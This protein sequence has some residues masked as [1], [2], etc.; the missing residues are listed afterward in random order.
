MGYIS[1]YFGVHV[2]LTDLAVR[3]AKPRE[4]PYK[5]FDGNGLYLHVVPSGARR[6]RFKYKFLGTEKLMGLGVYPEISLKE[7]RELHAEAR[8]LVRAN[9][10]P[11]TSRRDERRHAIQKI[12]ST[13][14]AVAKEWHDQQ[15]GRWTADHADRVWVSLKNN[16]FPE[17]G[18]KPVAEIRAQDVIRILRHI[19]QRDALDV[20]SRALQRTA[21]VLRYAV[22]TGRI[23]HNP[24]GDLR[25]VLKT[26]KVQHR[27]AM[28]AE[29]LPEFLR[30]LDDYTGEPITAIAL[31]LLLL[32]FVRPG[33]LR[34]A[35]WSEFDLE[36]SEWRIP[37]ERMKMRE[38]HLVPL[39]HQAMKLLGSLVPIS[40]GREL[41]FPSRNGQGKPMS[42]NT[43][44]FALY[45]MGY[46]KR[47]T[48]HGFRATASTI[49]N[50]HGFRPDVIER[51]LAHAE[52][53]KV[54]AAYHRSEY[55]AE[56][57]KMMQWWA[58]FLDTC[59]VGSKVIPLRA[60]R[61]SRK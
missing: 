41:L 15:R 40:G 16:V 20:A 34:G 32:T 50:E 57:R 44:T 58:D 23:E 8:K 61:R 54:R 13:F 53:N 18:R 42:E 36:K 45:R 52:R 47:A 17:L 48:A 11:I 30:K 24:A 21:A 31:R 60:R 35:R 27:P 3:R 2:A 59:T 12:E 28:K 26:R 46:H 14:E 51:Q 19:E 10:D 29:E 37:A 5:L 33:E 39:S 6:W 55:L 9:I 4:K 22:H 1:G 38:E 25:G 56:R 43:L 7:A 49:L